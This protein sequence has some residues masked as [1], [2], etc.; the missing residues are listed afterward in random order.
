MANQRRQLRCRPAR[1]AARKASVGTSV[2]APP[3][4]APSC[5]APS[6]SS[7]APPSRAVTSSAFRR[8]PPSATQALAMTTTSAPA[9]RAKAVF[10]TP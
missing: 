4:S 1:P 3:T 8:P 7:A 10:D 5:G 2:R 9:T 6:M